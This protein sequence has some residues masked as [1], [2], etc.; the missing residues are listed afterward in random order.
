MKFTKIA[1]GHYATA[2]GTYAVIAD[3]YGYVTE[4]E[5]DGS[6]IHAGI[7][8]GEW[9]FVRDGQGRL[10]SDHNV[11]ENIDWFPTKREA[12]AAA[13]ADAQGAAQR[14]AHA[15]AVRQANAAR[16][17]ERAERQAAEPRAQREAEERIAEAGCNVEGHD[18][19]DGECIHCFTAQPA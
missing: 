3:G 19:V 1:A 16:N 7:T 5:R 11:G 13:I 12:V 6:G 2:D 4:A 15:D 9:A 17:A 14:V 10:R 8:G 18:F